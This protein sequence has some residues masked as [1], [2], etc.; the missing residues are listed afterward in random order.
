M[1]DTEAYSQPVPSVL[2]AEWTVLQ[3]TFAVLPLRLY[4]IQRFL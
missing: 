1:F 4:Q 2:L 3:M